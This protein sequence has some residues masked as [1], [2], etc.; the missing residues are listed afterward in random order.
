MLK[1]LL[2]FLFRRQWSNSMDRATIRH[3]LVPGLVAAIA[4]STPEPVEAHWCNNIWAAPSRIVVKPEV[5]SVFVSSGKT[6]KLRVYVQNNLPFKMFSVEMRGT[7]GG[8]TVQVSPSSLD[9]NPGQNVSFIY[10]ISGPGGTL[11]VSTL[12]L[13]LRFRPGD[14]PNG[15]LDNQSNCMLNQSSSMSD[16][17]TMATGWWKYSGPCKGTNQVT[18]VNAATLWDKHPTEKISNSQPYNRTGVEQL[19][20]RFG[21]R[22]C[23]NGSGSW[24]GGNSDCPSP[25]PEG[26]A[27][28]GTQQWPQDCMR[29]GIELGARKS[30]LG[31]NLSA[32]RAG[33]TNALKGGCS[34]YTKPYQ[35]KCV[36]AV[37]GAYLWLGAGSTS[38]FTTALKSGGNCVPKGC[39]D[40]AMRILTSS[41]TSTCTGSSYSDYWTRAACAA[42]EGLR[43]NNGVVKS[44][45]IDR[46]G[47]GAQ[48][49]GGNYGS[50]Y[51]SYMLYLV[52]AAR[53]A[54]YGK[55]SYYPDAGAP[56]STTPDKSVPKPDKAVPKPDKKVVTPDKAVPKPDKKVVTPDKAVPKPDQKVVKKDQ[57]APKPD[58]K[59]VTLDKAAPKP[60]QKVVKKDQKVV[61]KDQKV[62]K[63]DQK[64]V[65]KDLAPVKKDKGAGKVDSQ[66]TGG[67]DEDGGCRVA[68]GARDLPGLFLLGLLAL[69]AFMRRRR[70]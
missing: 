4:L 20:K 40:A 55:V 44:I 67:G 15:W 28:A 23:W 63:K 35:H 1:S 48:P 7:A 41:P 9:I 49:Y 61:K 3:F 39:Q 68:P 69:F 46:A 60:D 8:Y 25:S 38:S 6:V 27:W 21:Y 2:Q 17:K 33:A 37:V 32:A 5:T 65:K 47:D 45:L 56:L 62:V 14:H 52:T 24:R 53:Q 11:Q 29:A 57:A 66:V 43:N 16:L 13:Q 19:I 58:K 22:F 26:S 31:S 59:V 70:R 36:A 10:S 12:G 50:L 30:K 34:L 51:Y 54:Q 64:A 18:A 42:A